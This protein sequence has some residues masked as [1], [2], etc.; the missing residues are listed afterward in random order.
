M[1][2]TALLVDQ[3]LGKLSSYHICDPGAVLEIIFAIW[4]VKIIPDKLCSYWSLNRGQEF[5]PGINFTVKWIVG[6]PYEQQAQ[7]TLDLY[8]TNPYAT[9]DSYFV[10]QSPPHLTALNC[11]PIF[12]TVEADVTVDVSSSIVQDY[13]LRTEPI[14]SS[15]AWTDAWFVHTNFTAQRER[16]QDGETQCCFSFPEDVTVSYVPKARPIDSFPQG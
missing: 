9:Q 7:P 11:M 15:A 1:R 14:N 2:Q 16:Q 4:L 6:N 12:E 8:A 5:A 10:W 13:S 3:Q